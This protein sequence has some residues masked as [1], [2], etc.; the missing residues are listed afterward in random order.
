MSFKKFSFTKQIMKNIELLGYQQPTKIQDQAIGPILKGRDVLGLAHT[1]TG[2]T[3][4]FMLPIIEGLATKN[5]NGVPKALILSPTRELAEQTGNCAKSLTRQLSINTTIVYGGAKRHLQV[6]KLQRGSDI[7]VA[8]PGRLLDLLNTRE[9]DLSE[10][11]LLVLD[12]ADQMLDQGFLPDVKRIVKRLPE[13]T[14]NLV[15]SATMPHDVKELC[16]GLLNNPVQISLNHSQPLDTISH[17]LLN[18]ERMAKNEVLKSLLNQDE[19]ESVIIFTRTKHKA[20]SLAHKLSKSG[21]KATS[22]QG[23]MSQN[24]RDFALNGFRRGH[25][26]ILVA[27]DIAARG[28]DIATISHVVNFDMPGSLEAYTHRTGRTGRANQ[29]GQAITLVTD[30]D[31][32]MV[33]MLNQKLASKLSHESPPQYTVGNHERL[34]ALPAE[35][36]E[37]KQRSMTTKHN[38]PKLSR[39]KRGKR[40][41]QRN[42]AVAFDFGI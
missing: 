5:R 23:N 42:R 20:R 16:G 6:S 9:I 28:I 40:S 15:F 4:A 8:C 2:K 37:G 39:K 1:G 17:T 21:F 24:Q 19:M 34:T 26:K 29:C 27:T 33:E 10:I 36:E 3:A 32:K 12:E 35:S 25:F 41:S 7:V 14:Q 38:A 18:V 11:E 30:D 22:L 13:T 31:S